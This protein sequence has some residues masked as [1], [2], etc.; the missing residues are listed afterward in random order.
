MAD[1]FFTP[2]LAWCQVKQ[3]PYDVTEE[4]VSAMIKHEVGIDAEG[5]CILTT[6]QI[7]LFF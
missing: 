3:A 1:T 4:E 5:I 2:G 7:S 6:R